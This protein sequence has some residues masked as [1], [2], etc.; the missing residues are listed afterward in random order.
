MK[1]AFYAPF[2]PF[3]HKNPSGDLVIA[4]SLV[5]FLEEKGHTVD[6]QSRLRARWIYFKPWLWVPLIHDFFRCLRKL[7]H[8]APDV[9]LT[10]H[11]YY[12]APD[13]LGPLVCRILGIK[14]IIFQGI[15][16]TKR[17]RKVK[18][19]AGFYLNLAAL[20]SACHIFTNKLSDLKNLKRLIPE[21]R[22]TYI[23]PGIKSSNF[24][25]DEFSGKR[26]RKKWGI[27]N[28]CPVIL[29]AAMF[30]D[31][32]KT[33]G[34]SWLIKCLGEL[35]KQNPDFHLVIAGTGKMETIL[36]ALVKKH[37]PGHC[38]FAGKIS[39]KDMY[40]FYSSGDI[41]AFPGIR[42][43]LGMV[44][45]EAQCCGLPVVAFNNGG[46]PEVVEDKKTGYL[47]PMYDCSGFSD[48][49]NRLLQDMDLCKK[50]GQHAFEYVKKYH[51]I[52]K[53]Y[54]KFEE[55]LYEVAA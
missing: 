41:F 33:K 20:K 45:L 38:T 42:E 31:D 17:K 11:T 43:S 18:T 26:L 40:R 23:K 3:G 36:K 4:E 55:I 52:D 25:Q 12:K 44:F 53:N 51:D 8:R 13:L 27:K 19:I 5:T 39:R 6:V 54:Q 32:V 47:V 35:V 16:S 28:S 7:K 2:K 29:S 9:W 49:L 30:R 46:I 15:Y 21:E 34:L 50:M 1:I 48:M 24:K 14:Y 22:L 10:Y 37:I